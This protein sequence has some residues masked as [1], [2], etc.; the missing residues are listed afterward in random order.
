MLWLPSV[1]EATPD[2]AAALEFEVRCV[3][4]TSKGWVGRP[5]AIIESHLVVPFRFLS[6]T[7]MGMMAG[8]DGHQELLDR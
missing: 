3:W 6:R 2:D 5:A 1:D 8:G 7:C 4:E